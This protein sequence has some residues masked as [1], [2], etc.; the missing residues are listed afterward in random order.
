MMYPDDHPPPHVH[1][2]MRDGRDCTVDIAT[3]EINGRI[4]ER[5]IRDALAWIESERS[6]LLNEWRRYNP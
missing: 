1:V 2:F 5:E 4:A 6:V 3:L